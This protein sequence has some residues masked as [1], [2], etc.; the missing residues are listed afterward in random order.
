M[1]KFLIRILCCFI[2]NKKTRH[3]FRK[4]V[5]GRYKTKGNNN[6]IKYCGVNLPKWLKIPGLHISINGNNNI[7]NIGN[8]TIFKHT[9]FLIGNS[10]TKIYIDT[11]S[12]LH[13]IFIRL[14]CGEKQSFMIG[15]HTILYGAHII[16]D[17]NSVLN[18]GSYCLFANNV[19][20]W[21]SDGHSVL[22]K[23]TGKI[24]NHITHPVNIGD[25]CWI[26]QGVRI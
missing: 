22:D 26:G 8:H 2:T 19:D 25:N 15:K 21:A 16:L 5:F 20:I 7:I 14:S 23:T 11:G 1:Q 3:T 24:L 17:E 9:T 13:G 10:D 4:C 6:I 12:E 18:I